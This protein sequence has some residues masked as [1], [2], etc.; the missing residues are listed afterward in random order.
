MKKTMETSIKSSKN[1]DKKSSKIEQNTSL[2]YASFINDFDIDKIESLKIIRKEKKSYLNLMFILN[3]IFIGLYFI[4][5]SWSLLL[6][7][8][9]I[10]LTLFLFSEQYH[11]FIKFTENNQ[12]YKFTIPSKDYYLFNELE[13]N[14]N[15]KKVTPIITKN[16]SPTKGHLRSQQLPA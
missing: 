14:L 12:K 13:K 7:H 10:Y 4:K 16:E 2:I 5:F 11:Y 9:I 8:S 15:S 1:Q 6:L 3:M